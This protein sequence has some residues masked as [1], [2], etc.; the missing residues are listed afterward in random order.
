MTIADFAVAKLN[1]ITCNMALLQK[2]VRDWFFRW[3]DK[4]GF[5]PQH[6]RQIRLLLADNQPVRG[7]LTPTADLS[8][9]SSWPDSSLAALHFGEAV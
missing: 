5:N 3:I 4:M 9:Q 2:E 6:N 7:K 1:T 8:W